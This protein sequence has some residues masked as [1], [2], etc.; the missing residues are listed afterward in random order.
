MIKKIIYVLLAVLVL[1]QFFRPVKNIAPVATNS[2]A[3]DQV[4]ILPENVKGILQK[5][6]FD[7]HSNTTKYPWYA[8]IQPIAWWMDDHVKEGKSELNFSIF[9]SYTLKKQDH[10]L[11]E[12][13]EQIVDEMPLLSYTIAHKE[14]KLSKV[15]KEELT[16]WVNNL[17]KEIQ[18]KM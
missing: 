13:S 4:Y 2:N 12:I 9:G 6:C 1:I 18:T 16:L 7:C 11:E 3:I 8:N 10:K 14:A 5:A 17:R 15:E